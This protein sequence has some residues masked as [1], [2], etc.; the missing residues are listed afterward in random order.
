M[1]LQWFKALGLGNDGCDDRCCRPSCSHPVSRLWL[2]WWAMALTGWESKCHAGI[3]PAGMFVQIVD[4][5]D[6]QPTGKRYSV[7][8]SPGFSI[9]SSSLGQGCPA[10]QTAYRTRVDTS[11]HLG[12]LQLKS[13]GV[14][15]MITT[16]CHNE[17]MVPQ[18]KESTSDPFLSF[19]PWWRIF[20]RCSPSCQQSHQTIRSKAL[21]H[22]R[23]RSTS[24]DGRRRP[25]AWP[26]LLA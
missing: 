6:P 15:S 5:L 21:P 23:P 2:R 9:Q 19:G 3:V 14:R 7:L 8:H 16:C 22:V 1:P 4:M 20:L 26:E 13:S 25:W 11:K 12:M 10:Q 24:G 18:Q 17:N